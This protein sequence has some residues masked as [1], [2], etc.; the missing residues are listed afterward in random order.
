MTVTFEKRLDEIRRGLY[1]FNEIGR[2]DTK[3]EMADILIKEYIDGTLTEAGTTA[4]VKY[5]QDQINVFKRITISDVP[6]PIRE[7]VSN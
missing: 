2:V 4:L 6:E 1:T 3:K 5:Y 7:L